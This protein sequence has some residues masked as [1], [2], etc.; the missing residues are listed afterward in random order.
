MLKHTDN[1]QKKK[2]E[3]LEAGFLTDELVSFYEDL[4]A[5][6]ERNTLSG[7]EYD[8][9][10]FVDSAQLPALKA[11]SL[12]FDEKTGGMLVKQLLE[13]LDIIEKH[14]PGINTELI[15][16]AVSEN[17]D[18]MVKS[19]GFLLQHDVDNLSAAATE[20]KTGIDE[21]IFI[22]VNWL[23]PLLV[24]MSTPA[25]ENV[26][27]E[28]WLA[29]VCPFCGY[30]ADMGKIVESKDSLRLLHCGL[31]E[32]EWKFPRL[33]CAICE[34]TEKETLGFLNTDDESPYR[35]DYCDNCKG[36]IKTVRI[37]KL[38]EE[39][40]FDLSVENILTTWLDA[41]ALDLGYSRP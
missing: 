24:S 22:L 35:V 1:F 30:L 19:A 38:Q 16:N 8:F 33:T 40:R 32:H 9:S 12:S 31:C 20:M 15:R 26:D 3:A 10:P 18:S 34:N 25:M 37:P 28:E 39:S 23:K 36:Y 11:D 7:E 4:F 5:F 29:P 17:I 14:H 6:Q 21:Y 27:T 41:S 2:D 13:L